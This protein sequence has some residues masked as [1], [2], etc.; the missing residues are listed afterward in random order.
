MAVL[1]G[2]PQYSTWRR[3]ASNIHPGTILLFGNHVKPTS[4]YTSGDALFRMYSFVASFFS[5]LDKNNI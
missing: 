2:M 4:A 3:S 1:C 5:R